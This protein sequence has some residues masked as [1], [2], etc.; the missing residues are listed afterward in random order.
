MNEPALSDLPEQN[1]LKGEL[2]H[3]DEGT[4]DSWFPVAPDGRKKGE[5]IGAGTLQGHVI[6][7]TGQVT[8]SLRHA[9]A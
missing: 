4:G 6:L 9:C 5:C 2:T 3:S 7:R 1:S 8:V